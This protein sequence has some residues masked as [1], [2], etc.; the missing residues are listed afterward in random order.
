MSG[1][2]EFDEARLEKIIEEEKRKELERSSASEAVMESVEEPV[3]EEGGEVPTYIEMFADVTAKKLGIDK[4][5]LLRAFKDVVSS[6]DPVIKKLAKINKIYRMLS[7]LKRV[8]GITSSITDLGMA[9]V[10]SSLTNEL[11]N[12]VKAGDDSEMAQF[13]RE[14][15]K[16]MMQLMI[17][18]EMSKIFSQFSIVEENQNNSRSSG[19][20]DNTAMLLQYLSSLEEKISRL[21]EKIKTETA[22][23][24]F[25]DRIKETIETSVSPAIKNIE[26]KMSSL[27]AKIKELEE[28]KKK[29]EMEDIINLFKNQVDELKKE[30]ESLKKQTVLA[31]AGGGQAVPMSLQD[32]FVEYKKKVEELEEAR[33]ELDGLLKK[34]SGTQGGVDER[35][36]AEIEHLRRELD[37]L[38]KKADITGAIGDVIKNPESV[39]KWINTAFDILKKINELKGA[40]SGLAG[41]TA[42]QVA[43]EE[44]RPPEILSKIL[45]EEESGGGEEVVE[46]GSE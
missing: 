37:D 15:K 27:E 46:E 14:M 42:P 10:A 35:T 31:V 19:P 2:E 25:F 22:E 34:L 9:R 30:F 8:G 1:F 11:E 17:M 21:E 41:T 39:K 20:D 4:N 44:V 45:E 28:E 7:S 23:K 36:K 26:E 38:R 29:K 5:A 13:L 40:V 6:E 24:S 32:L 33:K 16:T 18:R 3:G 43:E 12:V